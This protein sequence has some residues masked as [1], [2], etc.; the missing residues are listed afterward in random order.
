MTYKI[1]FLFT[2]CSEWEIGK[3]LHRFEMTI[4]TEIRWVAGVD[5]TNDTLIKCLMFQVLWFFNN[6]LQNSLQKSFQFIFFFHKFTKIKIKCLRPELCGKYFLSFPQKNLWPEKTEIAKCFLFNFWV[7]K[8][9]K[10]TILPNCQVGKW[11]FL[12]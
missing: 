1:C 6:F 7:I 10:T 3:C 8:L 5:G 11:L 12:I 4:F 2:Y 9:T